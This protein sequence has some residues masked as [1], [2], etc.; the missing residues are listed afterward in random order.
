MEPIQI[1]QNPLFGA[2]R[3]M[4]ISNTPYF[5]AAD[6]CRALGYEKPRNAVTTHVDPEDASKQGILTNGGM[7]QVTIINESGLYALIF[8]SKLDTAK[9][10]K[11]WVTS[12]VLPTIRKT[13]GYI[14]SRQEDT[15]EDIMARALLIATDTIDRQKKQLEFQSSRVLFARAVETS[16]KS[17]LVGEMAKILQQ[18]DIPIG[19]NRLFKYLRQHNYLC[20]KGEYYNL[21]TQAAMARRFFEIKKQTVCKPN[22]TTLV[23]TTPKITPTGQLH[24]IN[25]FL[26]KKDNDRKVINTK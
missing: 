10:F 19:Q 25:K 18:N 11:K 21:P 8:G 6:V 1:F 20:N 23:T 3:T 26:R 17:I 14:Q 24:L 9:Q 12:E 5:V 4:E 22:G 13:G 2:I 16:G 7:Q 15:Q